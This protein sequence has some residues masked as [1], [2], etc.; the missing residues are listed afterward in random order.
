MTK[1]EAA[2]ISAYTGILIGRF[3]DMHKYIEGVIGRP[4]LI[5]E[6]GSSEFNEKLKCLVEPD[7]IKIHEGIK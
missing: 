4:V 3:I 6:L 5:H 7:F 2:I 1:K